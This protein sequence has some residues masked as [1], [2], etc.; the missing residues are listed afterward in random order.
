LSA[1][2]R[3]TEVELGAPVAPFVFLGSGRGEF[4]SPGY[5]GVTRSLGQLPQERERKEGK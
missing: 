2:P 1:P 5:V 4:A 3:E